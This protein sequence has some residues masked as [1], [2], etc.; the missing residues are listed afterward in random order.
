MSK[1]FIMKALVLVPLLFVDRS[2]SLAIGAN[3]SDMHQLF[4]DL[5]STYNK[6][7]R[8][9]LHHDEITKV[10]FEIALYN[11]LSVHTREQKLVTNTE[12]IMKWEDHYLTWNPKDYNDTHMIHVPYTDIWY[13][14]VILYNTADSNYRNGIINTNAIISYTGEVELV[15]HVMFQSTCEVDIEWYPF[16][17]QDCKLH[18]ASWTYDMTKILLIQGP[19]D[20]SEYT[21]HPEFYLED[22][23]SELKLAH[24]PCCINPFSSKCTIKRNNGCHLDRSYIIDGHR[25]PIFVD[26]GLLLFIESILEYPTSL[27]WCAYQELPLL[28]FQALLTFLLPAESG[29]KVSLSTNALLAMMVFLMAM[30]QDIPPTEQVPLIGKEYLIVRAGISGTLMRHSIPVLEYGD[31]CIIPWSHLPQV[32]P[33]GS[34]RGKLPGRLIHIDPAVPSDGRVTPNRTSFKDDYQYRTV[35]ALEGIQHLLQNRFSDDFSSSS[36]S[37]HRMEWHYVCV[38]ADKLFFIVFLIMFIIFNI[39]ILLSSPHE[40]AFQYCPEGPGTCPEGWDAAFYG[41]QVEAGEGV[42]LPFPHGLGGGEHMAHG[43]GG[44]EHMAHGLGGGEHM[45]H[46]VG[47]GEHV[48]EG[49]H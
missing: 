30:T 12:M 1:M 29:E 2:C 40:A 28:F 19:A 10:F 11:I 13:P 46:G 25:R 7:V 16:D 24:D 45:A 47:G 6:H 42:D 37:I 35:S 32:E 43:V 20:L 39:I 36:T 17:Q 31:E 4:T 22:F 33:R 23:Y 15:S 49:S 9:V 27:M 38:V 26:F 41:E 34:L 48:P 8:P 44:G 3:K 14:D 21:P 18:F 5:F